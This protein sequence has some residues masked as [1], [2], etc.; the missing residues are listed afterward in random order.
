[1]TGGGSAARY[2][3]HLDMRVLDKFNIRWTRITAVAC[4]LR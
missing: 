3:V 1:M 2:H 4:K